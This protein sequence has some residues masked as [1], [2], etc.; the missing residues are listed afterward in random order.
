[1]IIQNW[2][3]CT[4]E[5]VYI[6][7]L[8]PVVK[9]K[10]SWRTTVKQ[11]QMSHM[12]S[13][14]NIF[15]VSACVCSPFGLTFLISLNYVVSFFVW[16]CFFPVLIVFSLFTGKSAV[17]RWKQS[18]ATKTAA[19]KAVSYAWR[20]SRHCWSGKW[21]YV[22]W[23]WVFQLSKIS[24]SATLLQHA[25][26]SICCPTAVLSPQSQLCTSLLYKIDSYQFFIN[27]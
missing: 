15:Y 16:F 22:F 23:G 14:K 8:V 27:S 13:N 1:M 7:L 24:F 9:K 5:A 17:G 19:E 6:H 3:P 20:T 11:S 26:C 2:V 12:V 18:T 25:M 21:S 10:M 4:V